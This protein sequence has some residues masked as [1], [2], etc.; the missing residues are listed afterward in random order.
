LLIGER[1]FDIANNHRF[2][3]TAKGW[4]RCV[5][6]PLIFRPDIAPGEKTNRT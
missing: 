1:V 6:W 3:G 5:I 4:R 2:V